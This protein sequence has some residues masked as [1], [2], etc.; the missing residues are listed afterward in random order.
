[1]EESLKIYWKLY[2][3][4]YS[5]EMLMHQKYNPLREYEDEFVDGPI[6][7]LGCGQSSFL[8]EMS[9]IG[10]EIFAVDNE[11]TQLGFL[12]NRITK[13]GAAGATK[14]HFLNLNIPKDKIPDKKFSIVIM[15]DFLH[16]FSLKNAAAIA[17]EIRERT[18]TGSLVYVRVH[19]K[20]HSYN[21]PS[22]PEINDYFKHFFTVDDLNSLFHDAVFECLICTENQQYLKS[23][24]EQ[25]LVANWLSQMMDN[26]G[27]KDE[28]ERESIIDENNKEIIDAWIT[29]VYRK[30]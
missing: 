15:S 7:E 10:K 9:K 29:C 13:Y 14:I 27:I 8:V 30:K 28:K 1:M 21:D 20:K 16:F 25:T 17:E 23:K 18:I 2:Y 22:D 19:S 11:E 24:H 3:D 26:E 6:L 5:N 12:N 4:F